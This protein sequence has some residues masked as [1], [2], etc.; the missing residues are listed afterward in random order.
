MKLRTTPDI[1]KARVLVKRPCNSCGEEYVKYRSFEKWC[2]D[3][4][5][6]V[7]LMKVAKQKA[8]QERARLKVERAEIKVRKEKL[9]SRRTWEHETQVEVNAL[10]RERDHDLPCISCGRFHQGQWHAGHFLSTGSH[11][12][13]RFDL[14]NIA[15]QCQPCNV[16]L[17][18]N[19]LNFRR[20]LIE[21]IGQAEVDRLEGP[22][23]PMK[24]SIDE[25]TTIK[26][27][28]K[29]ERR[30]LLAAREARTTPA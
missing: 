26:A 27:D 8:A 12:E 10:V 13:L 30:I 28:A 5:V 2:P 21:R 17:S 4:A 6:K 7:A 3:C 20:G 14:A 9:K 11:P 15:K 1:A 23:Q 22:Q 19:Q 24:Y 29:L 25:L 16:H 18:G